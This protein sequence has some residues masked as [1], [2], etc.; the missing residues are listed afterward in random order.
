[1]QLSFV[2]FKDICWVFLDRGEV[3]FYVIYDSVYFFVVKVGNGLIIV[4][5]ICFNVWKY[6][7]NVVVIVI[8]GLVKVCSEGLGNDSSLIFGMQ[9]S[10]YLGLL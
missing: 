4:I 1:M 3:Y 2:N 7:D 6:Q 5:G 9:V 10:Y 8:E